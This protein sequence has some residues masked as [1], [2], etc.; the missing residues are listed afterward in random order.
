MRPEPRSPRSPGVLGPR[1]LRTHRSFRMG[2]CEDPD[3]QE[4]LFG[5]THGFSW[6]LQV[7]VVGSGHVAAAKKDDITMLQ[8]S[9]TSN[10]STKQNLRNPNHQTKPPNQSSQSLFRIPSP[11]HTG[12]P[13]CSLAAIVLRD[14]RC[15]GASS[16]MDSQTWKEI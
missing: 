14:P 12:W 15:R 8:T 5:R 13:L 7:L 9:E 1:G 4:C 11:H 2:W 6:F 10:R 16:I 3:M